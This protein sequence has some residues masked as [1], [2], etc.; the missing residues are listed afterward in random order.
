M[1]PH[2]E[3]LENPFWVFSL[4]SGTLLDAGRPL[5]EAQ[6]LH[7]IPGL[8]HPCPC[9]AEVAASLRAAWPDGPGQEE[10]TLFWKSELLQSI[11]WLPYKMWFAT[12]SNKNFNWTEH[13]FI[14]T[15]NFTQQPAITGHTQVSCL[16]GMPAEGVH[17]APIHCTAGGLLGVRRHQKSARK[18]LHRKNSGRW[19]ISTTLLSL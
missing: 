3:V 19:I 18:G 1:H 16:T 12:P 9:G 17:R 5:A 11:I 14:L 10:L 8:E 6:G 4:C 2:P 7:K 13:G 15:R